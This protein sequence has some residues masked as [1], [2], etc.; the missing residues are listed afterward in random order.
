MLDT[1]WILTAPRG[2]QFHVAVCVFQFLFSVL[3]HL[4]P[5]FRCPWRHLAP[6]S[7]Y[8]RITTCLLTRPSSLCLT[9]TY[10]TLCSASFH[11]PFSSLAKYVVPQLICHPF[12]NWIHET[13]QAGRDAGQ[14]GPD[15]KVGSV[16]W[17]GVELF[18][19]ENWMTLKTKSSVSSTAVGVDELWL[20]PNNYY[21]LHK[22]LFQAI[23]S[24]SRIQN[25]LDLEEM[26][27]GSVTFDAAMHGLCSLFPH[28]NK[29][30]KIHL[31]RCKFWPFSY[32][33][34]CINQRCHFE[35][36]VERN[37]YSG[38]VC[39]PWWL[40]AFVLLRHEFYACETFVFHNPFRV[41]PEASTWRFREG[42]WSLWS[43]TLEP[44]S[45]VWSPPSWARW[46]RPRAISNWVWVLHSELPG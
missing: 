4:C 26:K 30:V 39:W 9:S 25:Y 22:I 32:C 38:K 43:A 28:L 13:V 33:R 23:V 44:E 42:N 2:N 29:R 18:S 21:F 20:L 19:P 3:S 15:L 17:L 14:A 40:L 10:S 7:R 24:F 31:L 5:I 45:P 8:Q 16:T 46:T 41:L 1:A 34:G 11:W 35:M 36:G 27:E 12:L 37:K 6:T